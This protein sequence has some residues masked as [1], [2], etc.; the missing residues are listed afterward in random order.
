MKEAVMVKTMTCPWKL[1]SAEER[2]KCDTFRIPSREIRERIVPG[3]FA[4]LI[5]TMADPPAGERMW[6]EVKKVEGKSYYGF[7]RNSPVSAI[8][9]FLSYGEPVEFGPEHVCAVTFPKAKSE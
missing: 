2:A 1:E 4:K 8:K 9:E 5:F 6:V 3:C 7:L